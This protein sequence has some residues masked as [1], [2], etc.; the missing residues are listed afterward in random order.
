MHLADHLGLPLHFL[1]T[2][3]E[4]ATRVSSATPRHV[5]RL[6]S[7]MCILEVTLHGP[8][9]ILTLS[10]FPVP[11]AFAHPQARFLYE[12][13]WQVSPRS[14]SLRGRLLGRINYASYGGIH[15]A[16]ALGV[17]GFGILRV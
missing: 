7:L 15:S 1:W 17:V 5:M 10:L 8:V 2:Q 11:Q 13:M 9:H 3:P 16:M 4:T 12:K 6:M 14:G